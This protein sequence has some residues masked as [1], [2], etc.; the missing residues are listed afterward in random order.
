M[1]TVKPKTKCSNPGTV[2]FP[3]E[4][5]YKLGHMI[6]WGFVVTFGWH[7]QRIRQGSGRIGGSRQCER[8]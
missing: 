1:N 3:W 5:L 7:T 6:Y 2:L 8:A 4:V